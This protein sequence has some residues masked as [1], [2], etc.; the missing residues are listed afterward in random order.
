MAPRNSSSDE[1]SRSGVS[2]MWKKERERCYLLLTS[3]LNGSIS[4]EH[5]GKSFA[6]FSRQSLKYV[7]NYKR[8]RIRPHVRGPLLCIIMLLTYWQ[9]YSVNVT[10][11]YKPNGTHPLRFN[12]CGEP[13]PGDAPPPRHFTSVAVVVSAVVAFIAVVVAVI[14]LREWSSCSSSNSIS[15]SSSKCTRQ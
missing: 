5:Q 12:A 7:I 8:Y 4:I 10:F 3:W 14:V 6:A 9:H 15:S 13:P 11:Q 1:A 2:K